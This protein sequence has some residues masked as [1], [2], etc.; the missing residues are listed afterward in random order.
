MQRQSQPVLSATIP[1]P[2]PCSCT[3][4]HYRENTTGL[5]SISSLSNTTWNN[6]TL[7]APSV[8]TE[9]ILAPSSSTRNRGGPGRAASLQCGTTA[10]LRVQRRRSVYKDAASLF[11]ERRHNT[12]NLALVLGIPS[13]FWEPCHCSRIAVLAFGAASLYSAARHGVGIAVVVLGA[14]SLFW[15]RR[16]SSRNGVLVL[17]LPSLYSAARRCPGI[18]VLVPGAA[19]WFQ[20]SRHCIRS[21]VLVLGIPPLF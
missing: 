14:A 15:D 21:G 1:P 2:P 16:H 10:P 20:E 5:N 6:S 3:A 19:S 11:Q 12:R 9:R 13:L 7:Y 17:G 18:A 8:K 4:T